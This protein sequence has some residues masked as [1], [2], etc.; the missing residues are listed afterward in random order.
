GTPG[1]G[2]G[3]VPS[4]EA[5]VQGGARGGARPGTSWARG[6]GASTGSGAFLSPHAERAGSAAGQVE[7]AARPQAAS[8]D[9]GDR[10]GCS[11]PRRRG[12][13]PLRSG[14]A[15]RPL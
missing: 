14:A 11:R 6:R 1:G 10:G 15:E 3:R 5:D 4:R 2:A 13:R 8:V 9:R 7:R 12:R